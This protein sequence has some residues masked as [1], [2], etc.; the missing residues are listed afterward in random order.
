MP[1]QGLNFPQLCVSLLMDAEM[2]ECVFVLVTVPVELDGKEYDVM[3]VSTLATAVSLFYCKCFMYYTGI[4]IP[5][6]VHGDCLTSEKC[7]CHIGWNGTT[8]SQR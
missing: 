4:C 7:L 5:P 3:N 6:C 1:K 2:E 8:C